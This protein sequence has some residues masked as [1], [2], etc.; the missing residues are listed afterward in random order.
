MGHIKCKWIIKY[1]IES[2]YEFYVVKRDL[3]QI[4]IQRFEK[5]LC[6]TEINFEKWWQNFWVSDFEFFPSAFAK[7]QN[8]LMNYCNRTVFFILKFFLKMI[9]D[10]FRNTF[11]SFGVRR[12]TKMGAKKSKLSDKAVKELADKTKCKSTVVNMCRSPLGVDPFLEESS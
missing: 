12:R 7:R 10:L 8:H 6:E 2:K 3:Q 9:R 5:Q 4:R 11:E 1:E